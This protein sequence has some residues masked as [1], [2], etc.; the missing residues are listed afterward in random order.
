MLFRSGRALGFPDWF[1]ANWDAWDDTLGDFV[2]ESRDSTVVL[3]EHSERLLAVSPA[4]FA[5]MLLE[6]VFAGLWAG[7]VDV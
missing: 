6:F 2:R 7:D 4:F 1:G 5:E 3:V